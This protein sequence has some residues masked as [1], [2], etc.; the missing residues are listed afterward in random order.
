MCLI[1]CHLKSYSLKE[2]FLLF[3]LFS[4]FLVLQI[5]FDLLLSYLPIWK[6]G[7]IHVVA[8][9]FFEKVAVTLVFLIVSQE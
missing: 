2:L 7:I 1:T 9:H 3:H 4:V 6:V 5:L 8:F